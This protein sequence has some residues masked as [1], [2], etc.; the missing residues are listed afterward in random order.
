MTT[1][2]RDMW[3]I[4]D[5]HFGHQN[6]I[7]WGDS[8]RPEF[9]TIEEMNETIIENWNKSV[10]S[11]DYVYHL[12]D[13]FF[14]PK[15]WFENN[16]FRLNGKIS[17]ILGNHD[18]TRYLSGKHPV[19]GQWFFRK[20]ETGTKQMANMGIMLSHFPIHKASLWNPKANKRLLNV[21]GHVHRNSLNED[22]YLNVSVEMTD[23]KP[24]NLEAIAYD[25]KYR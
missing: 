6:I 5:T 14:G 15:E 12:G 20:V 18:D 13:V 4:S 1:M 16:W 10:K 3:V 2:T 7:T 22:G 24:V 9:S 11:N 8:G 19:T 21:H 23:Y 25:Y 17:L